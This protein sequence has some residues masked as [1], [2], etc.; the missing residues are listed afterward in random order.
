M[1]TNVS[2]FH[3]GDSNANDYR[4]CEMK[5]NRQKKVKIH[6]KSESGVRPHNVLLCVLATVRL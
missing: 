2:L 6:D 3:F 4:E 5:R 1:D